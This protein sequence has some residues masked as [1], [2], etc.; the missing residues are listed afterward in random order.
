MT[1]YP[2]TL[3]DFKSWLESKS[4]DEVVG[5]TE[6][7]S[8]CPIATALKASMNQTDIRVRTDDTVLDSSTVKN[9]KWVKDFIYQVDDTLKGDV[10]VS[11]ALEIVNNLYICTTCNKYNPEGKNCGKDNCDW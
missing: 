8:L 10:T 2:L 4:E 5:V 6:F 1:T 9:P 11:R 7:C 3:I